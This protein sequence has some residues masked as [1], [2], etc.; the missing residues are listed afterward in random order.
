M[1]GKNMTYREQNEI[2]LYKATDC[3]EASELPR[4][5][6]HIIEDMVDIDLPLIILS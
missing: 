6:A 3:L 5:V 2:E 4:K 1:F